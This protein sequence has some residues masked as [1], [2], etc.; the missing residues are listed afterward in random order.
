MD[1]TQRNFESLIRKELGEWPEG[2]RLELHSD[3]DKQPDVERD[4][5]VC[6]LKGPNGEVIG[7]WS[8]VE[9][10]KMYDP[11]PSFSIQRRTA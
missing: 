4:H 2:A 3:S 10:Q 8:G 9:K 7:T 6:T 5:Y 11:A 1:A